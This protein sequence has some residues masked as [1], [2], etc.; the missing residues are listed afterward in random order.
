MPRVLSPAGVDLISRF[1]RFSA[2]LYNDPAGH[3][4]IGFGHLV[5]RDPTNGSEPEEFK[6]GMQQLERPLLGDVVD[7][8]Q[9]KEMTY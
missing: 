2:T 1:E 7:Q 5:R 6:A 3:C 9:T 8:V 4:T